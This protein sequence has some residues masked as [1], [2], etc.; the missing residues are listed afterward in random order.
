M[1]I[2]GVAACH[3]TEHSLV[4]PLLIISCILQQ[5]D[6]ILVARWS[7]TRAC[8]KKERK[9]EREGG[10][11]KEKEKKGEGR[12][13]GEREGEGGGEGGER[14]VD[15]LY[16]PVYIRKQHCKNFPINSQALSVYCSTDGQ[17][18]NKS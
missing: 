17:H 16:F 13:G 6:R 3:D 8:Q 15:V 14:T 5:E 4:M 18:Y 11:G 12:G 10:R 2:E 7:R 1:F 9:E